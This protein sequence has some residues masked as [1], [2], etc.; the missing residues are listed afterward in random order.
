M[1]SVVVEGCDASLKYKM[2]RRNIA[3]ISSN[4]YGRIKHPKKTIKSDIRSSSPFPPIVNLLL[5]FK[6]VGRVAGCIVKSW[7]CR[8]FGKLHVVSAGTNPVA[9]S[10]ARTSIRHVRALIAVQN[11]QDQILE[12]LWISWILSHNLT[13]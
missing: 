11:S 2:S 8:F 4:F 10:L 13:G 7:Q 3:E 1:R 6:Y 9:A 5:N 12:P